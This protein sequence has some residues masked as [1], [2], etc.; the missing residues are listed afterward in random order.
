MDQKSCAFMEVFNL[1]TYKHNN[2]QVIP[3]QLG[4][5][6]PLYKDWS[7]NPVE[8]D[9]FN[10]NPEYNLGILTG[11]T[12]QQ[13]VDIDIDDDIALLLAP[14]FLP[15]TELRFGREG[16]KNSHWL[17]RTSDDA[18]KTKQ[19]QHGNRG[20]IVEY[21]AN[22]SQSMAPPSI[23]PSG[24]KVE[25][26]SIGTPRMLS[27]SD[28]I[29]ATGR[30]AAATLLAHNWNNGLRHNLALAL[31]GALKKSDWS[32]TDTLKFIEAIAKTANDEEHEDR[33]RCVVD[34]YAREI[35][36]E[37]IKGWPSVGEMLGRELATTIS[38]WLQIIEAKYPAPS[39]APSL[40]D[41]TNSPESQTDIGNA[42]RFAKRHGNECFYHS[43]YGSWFMWNGKVW[44]RSADI[45]VGKLAHETALSIFDEAKVNM[46]LT[47]WA[48][49]S[50]SKSKL[51][52]MVETAKTYLQ[53]NREDMNS[54]AYLLNVQNGTL[55]L[56]TMEL[57]KHRREDYIDQIAD[58][59]FDP[60]AKCPRF[61]QFIDE[62][63]DGDD[64]LKRYVQTVWGY[65]LTGDTSEQK[66]FVG[67]G[68]GANGKGVLSE[69]LKSILGD[70]A[71]TA[72]AETLMQKNK[73]GGD[74]SPDLARLV[75]KRAVFISEGDRSHQFNEALVKQ[76][77]GQD[78]VTARALYQDYFEFTPVFKI[79]LS[80]NYLPKV[81][82][83]DE[84]IWRRLQ[85]IPYTVSF[86]G[87]KLDKS[88]GKRLMKEKSGILNWLLK[89]L[90]N[91]MDEGLIE[92]SAIKKAKSSYRSDSDNVLRFLESE[93][94]ITPYGK[95]SKSDLYQHYKYWVI[96]EG[97][98][99]TASHKE[100]SAILLKQPHIEQK[101]TNSARVWI[102]IELAVACSVF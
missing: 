84:G 90:Q 85:P 93:T 25:F 43:D 96:S 101:R 80:T 75:N 79:H 47:P 67:F 76:L 51:S 97:E 3:L 92:P 21:R 6:K 60:D 99:Y 58:A 77:T 36:G 59:I 53:K 30:L 14:H 31:S 5:K 29:N 17:Y 10:S 69:V 7:N 39:L 20:M 16:K 28:L 49:T 1:D 19:F 35:N 56:K 48:R 27:R 78:T 100:F 22:N 42:K 71:T 9:W 8:Y 34:T 38:N 37:D 61:E 83:T 88:L 87:E 33:V 45:T 18:G 89:G 94:R 50:C 102:G 54:D 40:Q 4:L 55:N 72:Q 57:Q 26:S 82:G 2:I 32:E 98:N 86:A 64:E 41:L 66:M 95:V 70:Y 23:H 13:L 15:N 63:F 52:A 73:S 46:S 11:E 81:R 12:S 65:T 44:V 68:S 24:E 74:A 91:W 62:I